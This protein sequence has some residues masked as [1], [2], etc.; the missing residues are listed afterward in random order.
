M[1]SPTPVPFPHASLDP[2]EHDLT[3]I[4][5]AIDLV[6]AGVATRVQLVGLTRAEAV[7]PIGLA[8]AQLKG[9]AFSLDRRGEG[10]FE[11][12]VGPRLEST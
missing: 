6:A 2:L 5:A 7:A 4:D 8:H 10:V 9:V 3:E 11:V 1:E 12:A